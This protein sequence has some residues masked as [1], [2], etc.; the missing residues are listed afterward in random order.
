[1]FRQEIRSAALLL[2]CLL[3]LTGCGAAPS[4]GVTPAPVPAPAALAGNWLIFGT[5]PPPV[6]GL[7]S[8]SGLVMTFD[9]TGSSVLASATLQT[10]CS[11]GTPFGLTFGAALTGTVASDGTFTVSPPITSGSVPNLTVH[12]TVPTATGQPWSGTYSVISAQTLCPVS[13]AGSFTAASIPQLT[14]TFTSMGGSI[15][16]SSGSVSATAVLQQGA[17]LYEGGRSTGV[18]SELGLAGS[19]QVTGFSCFSKGTVSTALPSEVEGSRIL[20]NFTMDDGSTLMLLGS[21]GNVQ[22]TQVLVPLIQVTGGNCN[23]LYASYAS[24]LVLQ[25]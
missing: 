13:L 4:T 1:M 2:V 6:T 21:L 16:G 8:A 14:G 3:L 10:T 22:A 23:G 17:P 15:T 24:P 5:V 7:S 19:V 25:R 12:G 9:V 18:S 11:S 20:I